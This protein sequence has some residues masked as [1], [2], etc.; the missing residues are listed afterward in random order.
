MRAQ[1][2]RGCRI[3]WSGT[4]E[5]FGATEEIELAN[6]GREKDVTSG[7]VETLVGADV[8]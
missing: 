6:C 3:T 7:R 4:V 2:R 8:Q 1:R 5:D